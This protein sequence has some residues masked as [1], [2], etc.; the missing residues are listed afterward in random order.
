MARIL[1]ADDDAV[2]LATL[3][4]SLEGDGH[5]VIC[6]DDGLEAY[7]LALSETPDMVFL[8][9]SL[10]VFNGYETCR[11]IRD[12]PEIA[13]TLPVVFVVSADADHLLMTQAGGTDELPSNHASFEIR[14]ML[15]KHLPPDAF[16]D[17]DEIRGFDEEDEP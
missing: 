6:A 4:A 8:S 13:A 11:M 9:V 7:E 1:A 17:P 3:T 12:D 2:S 14:D 10:P 5:E 16:P 15:A